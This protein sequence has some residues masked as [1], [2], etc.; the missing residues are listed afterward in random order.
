MI[1]NVEVEGILHANPQMIT[2]SKNV[3]LCKLFLRHVKTYKNK[4][5]EGEKVSFVPVT[6]WGP[7]ATECQN[8]KK[9]DTVK[10]I[11]TLEYQ[12][13]EVDGVKKGNLVVTASV[14]T[15]I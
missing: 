10:V 2:T 3:A 7:L 5:G 12:M 11:G 13:W 6:T 8:L 14:V 15:K 1:N 4:F 9:D